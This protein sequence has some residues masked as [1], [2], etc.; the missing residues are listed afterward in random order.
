MRI[1]Y[2]VRKSAGEV[3]I[4]E[5]TEGREIH[6]VVQGWVDVSVKGEPLTTIGVGGHFGELALIDD[7]KRSATVTAREDVVLLT[8]HRKDFFNL[9]QTEHSIAS[10]LLWC[11]LKNVAGRLRELSDEVAELHQKLAARQLPMD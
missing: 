7:Q 2:E 1:V 5:G 6:I 10:K 3:I 4:E 9:V 8:I 11:F